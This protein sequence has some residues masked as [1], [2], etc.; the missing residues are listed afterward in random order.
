MQLNYRFMIYIKFLK[1]CG[2][3]QGTLPSPKLELSD[4]FIAPGQNQKKFSL[5]TSK[6]LILCALNPQ[7]MD[8]QIKT[9]ERPYNRNPFTMNLHSFPW[10]LKERKLLFLQLWSKSTNW[11]GSAVLEEQ[12]DAVVY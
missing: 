6:Q 12:G 1:V 5:L 2:Y 4:Q 9:K 3:F 8:M 7:T 10:E 11:L